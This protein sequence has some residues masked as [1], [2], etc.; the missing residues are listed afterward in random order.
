MPRKKNS[1]NLKPIRSVSEAREKGKK[2]GISSGLARRKKKALQETF[3]EL[4]STPLQNPKMAENMQ[5]LGLPI[6]AETTVQ[7]VIAAAMVKEAYKGNV[8]A[9]LAIKDTVEPPGEWKKKDAV[10]E[11]L[12]LMRRAFEGARDAEE[13]DGDE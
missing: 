5:K 2:G 12:E 13:D 10:T 8:R 4:L 1:D 3:A 6:D 11:R 9:F 7:V